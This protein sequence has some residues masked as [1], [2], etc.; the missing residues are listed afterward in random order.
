M[1]RGGGGPRIEWMSFIIQKHFFR[2]EGVCVVSYPTKL[3]DKYLVHILIHV[4]VL[5]PNLRDDL[6]APPTAKK[7]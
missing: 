5:R 7:H 4:L 6:L 3:L 1:K 2:R